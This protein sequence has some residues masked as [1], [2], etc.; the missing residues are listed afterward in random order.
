MK[1]NKFIKLVGL[2]II[3]AFEFLFVVQMSSFAATETAKDNKSPYK[4]E[5]VKFFGSGID[6]LDQENRIYNKKFPVSITKYVNWEIGIKYEP[7]SAAKSVIVKQVFYN[8]DGTVLGTSVSKKDEFMIYPEGV[9]FFCW[10]YGSENLGTWELG[11]YKVEVWIDN[12]KIFTDTFE[13]SNGNQGRKELSTKEI[14]KKANAVLQINAYDNN[15]GRIGSGSGFI[16]SADGKIFTNY[17]VIDNAFKVEAVTNDNKKYS[18]EKVIGYSS[19][20]DIA[21][22]KLRGVKDLTYLT[23][24]DSDLIELGEEIIAIGSPLGLTNTV[25]NGIISS[26]RPN[27]FRKVAGCKDIQISAPISSGSSGGA[28][29]NIYGDVIGITYAGLEA[30]GGENLNFVIPINEATSIDMYANYSLEQVYV[31]EHILCNAYDGDLA[32]GLPNGSGKMTFKNGDI[33]TGD[34]KNGFMSGYGKLT[35]ADGM[36]YEGNWINGNKNG[37]GKLLISDGSVITGNWVNGKLNGSSTVIINDG[38]THTVYWLNDEV[39]MLDGHKV[40]DNKLVD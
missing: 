34:W 7:V 2:I 14:A 5:Y 22:L 11:K 31:K 26:I 9:S 37:E 29:F 28:L 35:T 39:I 8:P 21:I 6:E 3:I 19:E 4:L 36:V 10:G 23:M 40:K 32:N 33:Y 13:I 25:S 24:G 1:K 15:G 27:I 17:H 18:V 38:S 16:A 12:Y 30:L 20:K